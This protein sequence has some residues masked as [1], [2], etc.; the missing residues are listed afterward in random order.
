MKL[1]QLNQTRGRQQDE[2]GVYDRPTFHPRQRPSGYRP[3]V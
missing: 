2:I 3:A 1:E